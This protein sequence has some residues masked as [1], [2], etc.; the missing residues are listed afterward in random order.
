MRITW[1]PKRRSRGTPGRASSEAACAPTMRAYIGGEQRDGPSAIRA[2]S[3]RRVTCPRRYGAAEKR[4]LC[5]MKNMKRRTAITV[6]MSHGM[7]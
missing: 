3:L 7:A 5:V 4:E 2:S 6:T 1:E